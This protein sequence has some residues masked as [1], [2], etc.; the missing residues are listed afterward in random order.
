[1]K[2]LIKP[3]KDEFWAAAATHLPCLSD[4]KDKEPNKN[5]PFHPSLQ[6]ALP[7]QVKKLM[8]LHIWNDNKSSL[9]FRAAH[10]DFPFRFGQCQPTIES[11]HSSME[12]GTLFGKISLGVSFKKESK[13]SFLLR[14]VDLIRSDHK[15]ERLERR[16][17]NT[18]YQ[19]KSNDWWRLQLLKLHRPKL[20]VPNS[21]KN[22]QRLLVKIFA[23]LLL[24][25][26]WKT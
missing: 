6:N 21:S 15:E 20:T 23:L 4:K 16:R 12:L 7:A 17:G 1:M 5:F 8:T 18:R 11:R 14:L 22:E 25:F 24:L 13:T 9:G 2:W 19:N 3:L 10:F 26:F